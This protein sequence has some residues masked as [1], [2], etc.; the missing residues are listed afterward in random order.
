MPLN[1]NKLQSIIMIFFLFSSVVKFGKKN[2]KL[3]HQKQI[4]FNFYNETIQ[5]IFN[6]QILIED[7]FHV[8]ESSITDFYAQMETTPYQ[9]LLT[10]LKVYQSKFQLNDW[11]F[12][13]LIRTTI[14]EIYQG[15]SD[16]Q[17]DLTNWFFLTKAGYD[18]RLTY[19]GDYV[20]VYVHSNENIFETSLIEVDNKTFINLSNIHRKIETDGIYLNIHP[21]EPNQKGKSFSFELKQL[22]H[23]NPVEKNRKLKFQW[24]DQE[25]KLDIKFD[26]NLIK[27]MEHYPL[28][29]EVKYIQTPLS[30]SAASTLL[31]Q[32][33]KILK[34]KTEKEALE[35]IA[36]F[37]RSAFQYKDDQDYFGRNKPMIGDELFHYPYSDCEDRS[38]LFYYLV[39][40]LLRLPMIVIAYDDHLTIAVA[41]T[42]SIGKPIRFKN[43]KYFICDPTGPHNSEKIGDA[44]VGYKNRSFEVLKTN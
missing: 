12:Y 44:P 28:F 35:I 7:S 29:D 30:N 42:K 19:L 43:R 24:R 39:N 4:H 21:L 16:L 32:F 8:N 38:A 41:T 27:I 1:I 34:S 33:K 10:K 37:T 40:E 9:S 25:F 22:P 6:D 20:F 18:T 3:D 5:F 11:L 36:S 13:E 31:P 2:P 15:K 26:L 14:Q 17:M 23:F